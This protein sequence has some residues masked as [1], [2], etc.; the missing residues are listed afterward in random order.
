[1]MKVCRAWAISDEVIFQFQENMNSQTWGL[2]TIFEQE[3]LRS[4]TNVGL[5][6]FLDSAQTQLVL[7]Y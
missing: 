5:L 6:A 7:F 1:M 2:D 4:P 3:H